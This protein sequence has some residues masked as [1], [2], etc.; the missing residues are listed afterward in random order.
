[1]KQ[2]FTTLAALV[3][4]AALAATALPVSPVR[5][6]TQ[7]LH[8]LADMELP[9]G[10]GL[11]LPGGSSQ[12]PVHNT[13]HKAVVE[14]E[15]LYE[16]F[17]STGDDFTLP[18][19]W[20]AI[21]TP[22]NKDDVWHA[23][24][25]TSNGNVINGTSY[26]KY[27]FIFASETTDHDAWAISPG[28]SLKAGVEYTVTYT[29]YSDTTSPDVSEVVGAYVG[30]AQT[31]EAMKTE[32]GFTYDTEGLWD[33]AKYTFTPEKD[34]IY[35][36]GFHNETP[37]HRE[38]G[39]V[40]L[41]DDL[42]VF[43]GELPYFMGESIFYFGETKLE[44]PALEYEYEFYNGGTGPLNVSLKSSSPELSF[45]GL[46]VEGVRPDEVKSFKV[47]FSPSALGEYN[48]QFVLETNDPAMRQVTVQAVA[49][50]TKAVHLSYMQEDFETMPKTF[51]EGWSR[52]Y[53][54]FNFTNGLAHGGSRAIGMS[55]FYVCSDNYG[56]E[57]WIMTPYVAMGNNPV[58]SFWYTALAGNLYSPTGNGADPEKV[59]IEVYISSDKGAT[60]NKEY[61][62][63]P[64]KDADEKFIQSPA[65]RKLTL[66]LSKYAGKDCSMKLLCTAINDTREDNVYFLVDDIVFG[67]QPAVDLKASRM[68]GS[69]I[70]LPAQTGSCK[71]EINNT[72][73]NEVTAYKVNLYEC[74][75]GKLL[76]TVERGNIKPEGK[77]VIDFQFSFD[78]PGRYDLYAEV[79]A[80]GDA[81]SGNN[82][83]NNIYVE[84][85]SGET[86]QVMYDEGF[87][88]TWALN[89]PFNSN[90][91]NSTTQTIY[92]ANTLGVSEAMISGIAFRSRTANGYMCFDNIEV[93][94]G[95]T[96]KDEFEGDRFFDPAKMTKVFEGSVF[97]P[98]GENDFVVPFDAPYEYKGGNLV[99]MFRKTGVDWDPVV[100]FQGWTRLDDCP[101][102]GEHK[103]GPLTYAKGEV[104]AFLPKFRVNMV[105][106]PAGSVNGK[107]SFSDSKAAPTTVSVDGTALKTVTDKDGNYSFPS[108]SVGEHS[109]T[110]RAHGYKTLESRKINITEGVNSTLDVT[111]EALKLYTVKGTVLNSQNHKPIAGI[112][113]NLNGYDNYS[114]TTDAD[115]SFAIE[116]VYGSSDAQ[117]AISTESAIYESTAAK[118]N[119]S[120]DKDVVLNVEPS[121]LRAQ[122]VK[123][124]AQGGK[125]VVE[126]NDPKGEFHYDSGIFDHVIGYDNADSNIVFG[127]SYHKKAT[128]SEVSWYAN[129][130]QGPH[131]MFSVRI[132]GLT[133]YGLPDAKNILYEAHDV[134]YVDN[135]WSVYKLPKPI[136]ADGFCVGISCFGFNG[137]G[138]TK[139]S[140][141]YPFGPKMHYYAG[142]AYFMGMFDFTLW[143]P[144]HLMIRATV[145][146][147]GTPVSRPDI[148]YAVY[149]IDA[150]ISSAEGTLLGTTKDLSFEDI[151]QPSSGSYKYA[152]VAKYGDKAAQA[153]YSNVLNMAGVEDV[154]DS[155]FRMRVFGDKL[156]IASDIE[157]S[158]LV[159]TNMQGTTVMHVTTPSKIVSLENL[160]SGVYVAS[161]KRL[162]GQTRT[163]KI[164]KK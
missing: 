127:T 66:N 5:P 53:N 40:T 88:R 58:L 34:G 73:S 42:R 142:E 43:A 25:I 109:L 83:S 12:T 41:I 162:D 50:V 96:V 17:E 81:I 91:M 150:N 126:W 67:T 146:E 45:E 111:L 152:V 36:V 61:E 131:D 56:H 130:S 159:I 107:V 75:T 46:P 76:S 6:V 68:Q 163:I 110:F 108:L 55:S 95:E 59:K 156:V 157:L 134:P 47:K 115:G 147:E 104:Q 23:G 7:G 64:A 74:R 151:D 118:L 99:V 35:Y 160:S 116:N 149:R 1:M 113:V 29:Y 93:L 136:T 44:S 103:D 33:R 38:M 138:V 143:E 98:K 37:K 9:A 119:P 161:V 123:A 92:K 14:S 124:S 90:F 11:Y 26:D 145:E 102:L 137:M 30:D 122:A 120:D 106:A 158:D 82:R 48:G 31:K 79:V 13:P 71:L 28:V 125:I 2:K 86:V 164:A 39:S 10:F 18:D 4:L 27:A 135:A 139:S 105:V 78:R 155:S 60:W 132:F 54:A 94:V 24:T 16:D 114:A 148:E 20:K 69:A 97:F 140:D 57:S 70:L 21:A 32:L 80:E 72:G 121:V 101:T 62:I 117:Y 133:P 63:S 77:E 8:R 100:A 3:G 128:I 15:F 85:K 153:V 89:T 141:R 129:D 87:E 154:M 144:V 51:T 52:T 49:D 19:G 112:K 65:Y 22:G 84:V